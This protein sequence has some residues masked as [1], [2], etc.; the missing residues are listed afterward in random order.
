M[1]NDPNLAKTCSMLKNHGQLQKHHHQLV[2]RSSRIDTLQAAI[3]NAKLLHLDSWTEARIK[4]S[5]YYD[6]SLKNVKN[7]VVP[8]G[9]KH[10][11]H[12]YV[13]QTPLRER[14]MAILKKSGIG[15]AIHYPTPLPH[16]P[17]YRYQ[18][19]RLGDFPVA[20]RLSSEILSLPMYPEI[21]EEALEKVAKVIK[22]IF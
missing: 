5:H 11:F 21:E 14:L 10:V 19:H 22:E 3:L 13:I 4:A 6:S 12:L 17:S 16:V 9:S 2:G 18:G 1:T 15:C 7:P 20:E 8:E